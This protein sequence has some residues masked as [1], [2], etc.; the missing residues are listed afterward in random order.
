[1]ID[2]TKLGL[3]TNLFYVIF[4]LFYCT[5]TSFL[6]NNPT[7]YFKHFKNNTITLLNNTFSKLCFEISSASFIRQMELHSI[8]FVSVVCSY[9]EVLLCSLC[10]KGYFNVF[11]F[12]RLLKNLL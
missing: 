9:F 7:A 10:M 11:S 1:M 3:S 4:I 8:M 5:I 12:A 2:L 6:K